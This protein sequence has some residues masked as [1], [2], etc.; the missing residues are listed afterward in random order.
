MICLLLAALL[1]VPTDDPVPIEDRPATKFPYQDDISLRGFVEEAL[2]G[3]GTPRTHLFDDYTDGSYH[4]R[5]A[6]LVEA[7]FMIGPTYGL[8]L[9]AAIVIG[10]Y[11]PLWAYDVVTIV[12]DGSCTRVNWLV[13]PHAR[14]TVK[15]SG[16]LPRDTVH[17]FRS[18]IQKATSA[19]RAGADTSCVLLATPGRLRWSRFSCDETEPPPESVSMDEAIQGMLSSL[20]L[21]YSNYPPVEE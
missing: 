15:R 5:P 14:I 21:T 2:Y 9:D 18:S 10:P 3:Y 8:E 17:A 19:D 4:V 11:G 7:L 12:D 16:C 6:E 1:V 13:M 20:E